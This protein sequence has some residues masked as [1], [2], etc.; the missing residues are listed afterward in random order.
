M[1]TEIVSLE[2]LTVDRAMAKNSGKFYF[3]KMNVI[4]NQI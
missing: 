2:L 1:E 3:L 4:I